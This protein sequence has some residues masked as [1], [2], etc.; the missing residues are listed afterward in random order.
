MIVKI[1]SECLEIIKVLNEAGHKAYLVGGSVRDI[2][3]GNIPHDF[4]ITTSATPNEV[5]QLFDKTIPT[6]IDYGTI[7]IMLDNIGYEVTTFRKDQLYSDGRRPDSITFSKTIEDDLARRDFTINAIAYDPF[8]NEFIDPFNGINDI[9]N[10]I[11]KAVG[12]PDVRI[13][14]DALR[15]LRGYRFAVKYHLEIEEITLKAMKNNLLLINQNVSKER[16]NCELLK[17]LECSLS[18]K[19]LD[20]LW[21]VF[22]TIFPILKET[23]GYEQKNP[24]HDLTLDKHILTS[25]SKVSTLKIMNIDCFKMVDFTKLRLALLLHDIGKIHT[26][27]FDENNVAHYYS[28]AE[29]SGKIAREILK[30]LK[31]SNSLVNDVVDLIEKHQIVFPQTKKNMVK[32]INKNGINNVYKYL[33]IYC[34]DKMSHSKPISKKEIDNLIEKIKEAQLEP[35]SEFGL[36]DLAIDGFDVI[37]TTNYKNKEIGILLNATLNAVLDGVVSNTK[38]DLIEFIKKYRLR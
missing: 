34:A 13:K 38:K 15:V 26:Q 36:K 14:E 22:A 5:I 25:V 3:M 12:N 6:G 24:H 37:N 4:D 33:A 27:T 18:M 28:H 30:D 21:D 8:K 23:E 29:Q 35:M 10:K 1:P 7:T 31:F 9:N 2:I 32:F 16:I 20:L 11:L 19:E 17:I